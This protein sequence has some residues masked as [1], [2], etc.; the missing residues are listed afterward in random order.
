MNFQVRDQNPSP[1]FYSLHLYSQ[2]PNER[3]QS[4]FWLNYFSF[5]RFEVWKVCISDKMTAP[6]V[7]EVSGT[8]SA[9]PSDPTQ[10]VQTSIV[11]RNRPGTRSSA[12]CHWP[13]EAFEN[14]DSTLA[15]QQYIQQV[16]LPLA[17]SSVDH[18]NCCIISTLKVSS[19]LS[20]RV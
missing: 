19:Q 4:K 14:M 11:R 18:L 2:K 1:R 6:A 15:V 10:I 7:G 13:D 8:T 3:N 12:Y 16:S 17:L 9:S 20:K 5:I